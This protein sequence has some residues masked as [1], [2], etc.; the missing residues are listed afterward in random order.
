[1]PD[2]P[3]GHQA[4]VPD[5]FGH[6]R[7]ARQ[8]DRLVTDPNPREVQNNFA[9]SREAFNFEDDDPDDGDEAHSTNSMHKDDTAAD[10]LAQLPRDYGESDYYS[11]LGL[12]REPPP[13]ES[14]LTSAYRQLSQLLHPDRQPPSSR[15]AAA[16]QYVRVQK[17]Y[18][19]LRD[20]ERKVVY[21]LLGEEGVR[22]EW[23]QGGTMYRAPNQRQDVG[24][25][26][27]TPEEFREWFIDRMKKREKQILESLVEPRVCQENS[28]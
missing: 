23:D 15:I 6:S 12:S 4:S 1:M 16:E 5:P 7:P 2:G 9:I 17:A 19:T 21:D 24:Q 26:A 22:A 27:K 10:R 28:P 14:Q 18:N 8:A 11:L 3:D 20:Q 25:R 13:T